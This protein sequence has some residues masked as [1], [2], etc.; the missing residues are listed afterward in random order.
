MFTL[1]LKYNKFCCYG[2]KGKSKLSTIRALGMNS[3]IKSNIGCARPKRYVNHFQCL[4]LKPRTTIGYCYSDLI[5]SNE[6]IEG[7]IRFS[8]CFRPCGRFQSFFIPHLYP[9]AEM[10]ASRVNCGLYQA[11]RQD[12]NVKAVQAGIRQGADKL[13]TENGWYDV[14]LVNE[15]GRISEGSRSNVFLLKIMHWLLPPTR[16]YYPE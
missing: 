7:N 2:K 6:I 8:Y 3:Y 15:C 1:N 10:V 16:K 5:I 11:L 12:P 9:T 14:L 13:M 4:T